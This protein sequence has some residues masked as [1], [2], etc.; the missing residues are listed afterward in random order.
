MLLQPR[1]DHKPAGRRERGIGVARHQA[2]G[3]AIGKSGFHRAGEAANI[4][5]LLVGVGRIIAADH[6]G[7]CGRIGSENVGP[8]FFAG[9]PG[10]GGVDQDLGQGDRMIVG[11]G[12]VARHQR[13]NRTRGRVVGNAIERGIGGDVGRARERG[14]RHRERPRRHAGR[15]GLVRGHRDRLGVGHRGLAVGVEAVWRECHHQRGVAGDR[16]G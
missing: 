6:A 9:E 4:D 14:E 3:A 1:G 8:Q 7:R 5:A 10:V 12:N 2:P 11:V 16:R 13:G 15:P